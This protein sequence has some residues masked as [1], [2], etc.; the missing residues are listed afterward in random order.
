VSSP[1]DVVRLPGIA[2]PSCSVRFADARPRRSAPRARWLLSRHSRAAPSQRQ[3]SLA[4]FPRYVES[5]PRRRGRRRFQSTSQ[6][7]DVAS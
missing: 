3:A 7:A 1:A 5:A 2:P 6:A 4:A